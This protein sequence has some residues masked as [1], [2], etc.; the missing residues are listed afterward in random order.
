MYSPP[1]PQNAPQPQ[2]GGGAPTSMP[3][4]QGAQAG[5]PTGQVDQM[6]QLVA[7]QQIE[8]AKNAFMQTAQAVVALS[9]QFPAQAEK[10][11]QIA[12]AVMQVSTEAIAALQPSPVSPAM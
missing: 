7:Q 10:L 4:P 8:Q 11:E 2:M 9:Q 3:P 12:A 1:Q 6:A 5:V